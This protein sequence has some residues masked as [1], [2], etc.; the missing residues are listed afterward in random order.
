VL[1]GAPHALSKAPWASS[2]AARKTMVGNRRRDTRPELKVRQLLH[3]AGLRYRIDVQPLPGLRRR[4]DVVFRSL[5]VAVFIDGCYWH[6]CPE[7]GTTP[8]TNR[9]YWSAKVAANRLRDEDT[10]VR[11]AEA[12]WCVARYWEHEPPEDVAADVIR[13][14]RERRAAGADRQRPP[15]SND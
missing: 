1:F 13:I 9:E 5:R 11:L 7:H 8:R 12:G 4:A 15:L 10:N 2:E 14:I 6:S 3:G